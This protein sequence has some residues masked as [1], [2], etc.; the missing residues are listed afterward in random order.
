MASSQSGASCVCQGAATFVSL[1]HASNLVGAYSGLAWVPRGEDYL[2]WKT[3]AVLGHGD[4]SCCASHWKTSGLAK[5]VP[6]L[7]M[8]L[9]ATVAK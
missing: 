3:S 4:V 7:M 6:E 1:P 8:H 9:F 5:I 2:P